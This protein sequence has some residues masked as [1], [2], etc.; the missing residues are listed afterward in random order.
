[1]ATYDTIIKSGMLYDG[2]GGDPVQAD[3]GI[4]KDRIAAIGQLTDKTAKVINAL[5]KYVTPGF[6]DITNHSDTHLTIFKYPGL[7]SMLMQGITTAIGGN[8]GASLAPLG[9]PD[10]I[11]GISKWADTSEIN[12][13]WA[14]FEEYLGEIATLR[15]GINFGSFVGY[16]TLRRGVIGD[17]VRVITQVEREKIKFLLANSLDQGA[18]GL[19]LGLSYGHEAISPIE[20]LIEIA[21]VVRIKGGI[22]KIHLRSE[23]KGLLAA[24][25]EV[26]R[27]GREAGVSIQISHLKAIGGKSWHM[28][29]P[30]LDIIHN[31]RGSGLNINFDVSPY[32]TTGSSLYLLIPPWA[33]EGGFTELFKRIDDVTERKKIID[34]LKTYTLHPNKILITSS[35][36]K[37]IVG[38]TLG[39]IAEN[40]GI[41]TEEALLALVR[42]SQG[43]VSI[44]GRTLSVRNTRK[45]IENPYSFIASDGAG[46]IETAS[47]SGDLIHPR[48]FGAFAHFWHRFVQERALINPQEAIKKITFAV[49]EKLKLRH[50]GVLAKDYIADI[51]IF[52]PKSFKE[53]STYRDP[54]QYAIGMEWVFVNGKAAVQEGKLTHMRHGGILKKS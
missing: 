22:L 43:R 54:Y 13:N 18:F 38:K 30:A 47:D 16:G 44:I 17:G 19:S 24:I 11:S 5:G 1:M 23:G 6:I 34:T 51:V 14:T 41:T 37:N 3:I 26:V 9:S 45:E 39:E 20:E 53:R 25:N 7:E 40:G 50:R 8:C 48:S 2:K 49:A 42:T 36:I 10:A 29:A 35:P 52:D 15:P 31:A 33:R 27:I 46:Y 28:L 4:V 21:H 12:I 32:A